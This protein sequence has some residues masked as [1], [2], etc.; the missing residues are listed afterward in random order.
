MIIAW[1]MLVDSSLKALGP[2]PGFG[3]GQAE[4]IS[5]GFRRKSASHLPGASP[6]ETLLICISA[7]DVHQRKMQR[8]S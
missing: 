3:T 8:S 4:E 6:K 5:C 2:D 1:E 7:A